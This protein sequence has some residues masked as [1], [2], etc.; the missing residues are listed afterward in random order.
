MFLILISFGFVYHAKSSY[1]DENCPNISMFCNGI[2]PNTNSG[3]QRCFHLQIPT[4]YQYRT[5]ITIFIPI[6]G[7]FDTIIDVDY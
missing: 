7:F 4:K 3:I 1:L 2:D 6:V 5:G